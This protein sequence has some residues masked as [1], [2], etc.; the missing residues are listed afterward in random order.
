MNR[1]GAGD[2]DLWLM[3]VIFIAAAYFAVTNY[4]GWYELHFRVGLF[5]F[6]HWLSW[7]GAVFIGLYTPVYYALKRRR[8]PS[9]YRRLLNLHTYGSL[10]A[11]GLISIHFT[12]EVS[13]PAGFAPELGTGIIMYAAMLGLV[14]TGFVQRFRLGGNARGAWRFVHNS[15]MVSFYLIIVVHI[16]HG[17]GVL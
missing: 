5:D 2:R 8:N 17:L 11:F 15:L 7:T 3:L 9:R 1:S 12:G 16:L 6:H 10:I 4:L 14:V 13:R